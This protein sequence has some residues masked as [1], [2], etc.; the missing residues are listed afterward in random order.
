M[1]RTFLLT[2]IVITLVISGCSSAQKDPKKIFDKMHWIEGKWVS[3][4]VTN[5][6]EIWKRVN[7][8]CYQGLS[9][10]PSESDSL[11][12]E[13]PRIVL[14]NNSILFISEIEE[15]TI[16]GLTQD[17]PMT[18]TSSDTLVF[19]TK[20]QNYP[21]TITYKKMSDSLIK[22]VVERKNAEGPIKFV[23]TL[24]KQIK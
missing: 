5:Y 20:G 11:V 16:E 21:N 22:V 18:S 10:S 4:D 8:T 14:R 12:E 6:S 7:D 19:A 1:N 13:R 3:T 2:A 17:F 24:K 9:V 15:Q 23:Y